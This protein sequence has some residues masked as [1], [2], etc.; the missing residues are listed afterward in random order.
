MHKRTLNPGKQLQAAY[1]MM[2]QVCI[3]NSKRSSDK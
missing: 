2:E 1:D 3:R